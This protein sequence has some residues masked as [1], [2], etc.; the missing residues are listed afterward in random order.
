[1]AKKEIE[2]IKKLGEDKN[3]LFNNIYYCGKTNNKY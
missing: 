1:M 3:N 2:E